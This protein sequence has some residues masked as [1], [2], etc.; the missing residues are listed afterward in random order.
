MTELLKHIEAVCTGERVKPLEAVDFTLERE[1]VRVPH[2][3]FIYR[4]G[5]RL[6]LDYA[7]DERSLRAHAGPPI[8]RVIVRKLA[9]AVYGDVVNE[10]IDVAYELQKTGSEA[11]RAASDR[12]MRLAS[13]MEGN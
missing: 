10:V 11:D 13:K 6:G 7:V 9:R 1:E 12:L 8:P 4:A 5:L 2:P 3:K